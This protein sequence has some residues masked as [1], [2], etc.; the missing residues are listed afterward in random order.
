METTRR[1]DDEK[2]RTANT[3]YNGFGQLAKFK[4][5]LVFGRFGKSENRA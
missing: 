4:N 1:I 2:S 3:R 5:G